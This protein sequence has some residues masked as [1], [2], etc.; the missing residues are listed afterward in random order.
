[1]LYFWH[2]KFIADIRRAKFIVIHHDLDL[3]L[4]PFINLGQGWGPHPHILQASSVQSIN[5]HY[6]DSDYSQWSTTIR[7]REWHMMIPVRIIINWIKIWLRGDNGVN[8]QTEGQELGA[9]INSET[10]SCHHPSLTWYHHSWKTQ[11]MGAGYW[12]PDLQSGTMIELSEHV[13]DIKIW[14]TTYHN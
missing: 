5:N 9:N 2:S 1:M 14:V 13:K 6:N 7:C 10:R 3:K 8:T 4:L 12:C 11:L